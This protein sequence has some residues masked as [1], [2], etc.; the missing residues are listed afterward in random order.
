MLHC[1]DKVD[2]DR[3]LPRSPRPPSGGFTP[4]LLGPAGFVPFR[5]PRPTVAI[6][7][8]GFVLKGSTAR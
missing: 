3:Q 8:N 6:I 4:H 1:L 7:T 5:S 2:K